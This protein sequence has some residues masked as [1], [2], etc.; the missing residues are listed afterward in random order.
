MCAQVDYYVVG[1]ALPLLAEAT[2]LLVAQFRALVFELATANATQE[3]MFAR[4]LARCV[5]RKHSRFAN[6]HDALTQQG[7]PWS[8]V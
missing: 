1:A 7:D 8:S 6:L 5:D 4:K 2:R 3:D